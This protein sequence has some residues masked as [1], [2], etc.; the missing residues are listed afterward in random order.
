MC[1]NLQFLLEQTLLVE[2]VSKGVTVLLI[3][4]GGGTT[5][6]LW[7]GSSLTHHHRIYLLL[8]GEAEQH[9]ASSSWGKPGSP[10]LLRELF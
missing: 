3:A 1:L 8:W 10:R 9:W 2:P 7:D 4:G 6:E 5:D